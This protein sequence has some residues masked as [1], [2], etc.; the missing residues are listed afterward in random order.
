MP[1][2]ACVGSAALMGAWGTSRGEAIH[3]STFL[4]HPLACAAACAA[5]DVI[6]DERLPE[7]AHVEGRWL[8]QA[9]GNLAARH[10]LDAPRG[11][12]LLVGL[13]IG[14]GARTL[15]TIRSLLRRGFVV[16]PA[17]ADASVLAVHPP[18]TI[19]SAQLAAFVDALDLA[20]QDGAG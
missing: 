14:D 15:R 1:L 9:L 10:G 16:L 19:A 7:R 13:P 18:L 8:T 6:A 12:G 2:S 5:L 4:G 11:R 20:I 17:G 3:T